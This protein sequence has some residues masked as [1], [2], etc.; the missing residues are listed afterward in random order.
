MRISRVE[1]NR[2]WFLWD[3]EQILLSVKPGTRKY[4]NLRRDPHLA[5]SLL[6]ASHPQRYLEIR[7]AVVEFALYEDLTFVN[8]L[9]RKDTGADFRHGSLG[10]QRDKLTIRVN[11]RTA[12]E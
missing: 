8:Q 4:R 2:V 5:I 6:A 9:A 10:E 3:G 1:G 7:G 11:A 12:Q